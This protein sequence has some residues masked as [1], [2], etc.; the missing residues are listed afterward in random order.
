M[1]FFFFI[2]INCTKLLKD[3]EICVTE[4]EVQLKKHLSEGTEVIRSDPGSGQ[5][6]ASIVF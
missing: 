6:K 1:S 5:E 4:V 2:C 3:S